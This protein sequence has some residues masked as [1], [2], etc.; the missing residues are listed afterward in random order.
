[1]V[2][3]RLCTVLLCHIFIAKWTC[4]L[5]MGDS[6]VCDLGGNRT[7]RLVI[8]HRQGLVWDY[9]LHYTSTEFLLTLCVNGQHS[10]IGP[11]KNGI[12]QHPRGTL[13]MM[14]DVYCFLLGFN[15]TLCE[16]GMVT[17]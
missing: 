1:M 3:L 17:F 5:I 4:L 15:G 11:F 10:A 8:C 9:F 12:L 2:Q 6:F 14:V 7:E 16:V 13:W